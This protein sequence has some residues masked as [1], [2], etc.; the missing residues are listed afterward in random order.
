VSRIAS[1]LPWV[2]VASFWAGSGMSVAQ[3]ADGLRPSIVDEE[4]VDELEEPKPKAVVQPIFEDV[5]PVVTKKKAEVVDPFAAQ[6]V[7]H[8]GIRFYPSLEI[9]AVAAT[10]AQQSAN[11]NADIGL[12]LRPQLRFE[13]DWVRHAWTG[14]ASAELTKFATQEDTDA[15]SGNLETAYRLDIRKITKADFTARY[16]LSQTSS[17]DSEVPDTAIGARREH[18][19]GASAALT[20]NYGPVE[21]K[22]T[23]SL[24][25]Q[26]YADVDLVGG[27]AEDNSDRNYVE[28]SIRLR[29]TSTYGAQI[30]P[31]IEIA[32]NPRF[33]DDALDRSSLRRNSHGGS[34]TAGVVLD[35]GPIW[36][37]EAGLTYSARSYDDAALDTNSAFG[38]NGNLTWRPTEL[39]SILFN[40]A[41]TLNESSSPTSS[42]SVTWSAGAA[43]THNLRE[44]LD[45]TAGLNLSLNA[46]E[47]GNDLTTT[48]KLGVEWQV[49]PNLS[50]TAGY[51]V[52]W[53]N[54]DNNAQD[55]TDHRIMTSIVLRP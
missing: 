14:S 50:W 24:A 18:T 29:G 11:G 7:G 19:F 13:S 39:T 36:V 41:T 45:L 12:R 49:N 53:F 42:G 2:V 40:A 25:R 5:A 30:N 15:L 55:W 8:G 35:R 37:G 51:D 38:L 26:I 9:G 52:T 33:H 27:G 10:N 20:H 31:F 34:I 28:P 23:I 4:A 48:G 6:Y 32:Y 47:L 44:N 1:L 54:A 21:G 46:N 22:A 43:A 3:E 17:A 16:E